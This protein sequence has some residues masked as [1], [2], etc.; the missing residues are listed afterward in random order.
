LEQVS[1]QGKTFV[2]F[3]TKDEIQTIIKRLAREIEA[4]YADIKEPIILISILDGSFVFMA[5]LVREINRDIEIEFVK[6]KSYDGIRSR[7]EVAHHLKLTRSLVGRHI[8]VVEDII[9]TGLTID[10]FLGELKNKNTASIKVCALLSK[11]EVH[12]DLIPIEFLGKEIPPEFVI[13]YG[14]DIDG[15]GRNLPRIYKLKV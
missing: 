11:P 8:L 3:I 1:Y 9:D 7:G 15:L 6:L 5:D 2:S 10:H 12:N 14:L 4:S 13:G